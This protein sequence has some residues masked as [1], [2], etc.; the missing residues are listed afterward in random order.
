MI[1]AG[2]RSASSAASKIVGVAGLR[3]AWHISNT[4]SLIAW[5]APAARIAGND[6]PYS[7]IRSSPRW[8]QARCGIR[9][10]SGCVPVASDDRQTGVSD[11]NVVVPRV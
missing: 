1:A 10:S 8:Y 5:R 3:C 7:T 9:C 11:G 6:E 4:P 2:T